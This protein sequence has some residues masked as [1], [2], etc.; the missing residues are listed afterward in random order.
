MPTN[1]SRDRV[2]FQKVTGTDN[3]PPSLQIISV[4]DMIS[5]ASFSKAYTPWIFVEVYFKFQF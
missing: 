5:E 3:F 2:N 4:E 1:F